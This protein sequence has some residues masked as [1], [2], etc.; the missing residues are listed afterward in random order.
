MNME[1]EETSMNE[2]K[3]TSA[4]GC[5]TSFITWLS[6]YALIAI[7]TLIVL[8]ILFSLARAAIYKIRSWERGLH[9]RGGKFI[10]I[11]EPGWHIQIPF[12][13]TVIGVVVSE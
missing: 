2:G 4:P 11:D 5:F 10:G 8:G 13:D 3:S 1:P 6:K 12:V 9:V 7:L